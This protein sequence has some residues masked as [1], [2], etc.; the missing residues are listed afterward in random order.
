[1]DAGLFCSPSLTRSTHSS[2]R[3]TESSKCECSIPPHDRQIRDVVK[4]DARR[5]RKD[6]PLPPLRPHRHIG[7]KPEGRAALTPAAVAATK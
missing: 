2:C 5:N 1:M 7:V 6:R 4:S 3:G